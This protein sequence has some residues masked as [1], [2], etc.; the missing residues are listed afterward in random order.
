MNTVEIVITLEKGL[1]KHS[2]TMKPNADG[3]YYLPIN[4][5]KNTIPEGY[6][7]VKVT[8]SLEELS[9][10]ITFKEMIKHNCGLT[11][12]SHESPEIF[13]KITTG[14]TLPKTGTQG[15]F[16]MIFLLGLVHVCGFATVQMA[17][18]KD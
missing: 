12:Q 6:Y 13:P 18:S 9:K 5:S 8:A 2:F 14:A 4:S 7:K 16:F 15:R 1:D 3:S 10:T 11:V 17:L